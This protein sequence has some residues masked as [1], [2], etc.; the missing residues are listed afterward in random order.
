MTSVSGWAMP[1]GIAALH[2]LVGKNKG[3]FISKAI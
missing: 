1:Y 3:R 2:G